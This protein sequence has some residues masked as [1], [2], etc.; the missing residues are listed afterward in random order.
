MRAR[1]VLH[2]SM[3]AHVP[4]AMHCRHTFTREHIHSC[5][6]A[7]RCVWTWVCACNAWHITCTQHSQ[8]KARTQRYPMHIQQILHAYT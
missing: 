6:C 7:W 4:C 1:D 5:S 8:R 2:T 3:C